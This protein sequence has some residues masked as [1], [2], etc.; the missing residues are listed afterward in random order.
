MHRRHFPDF[1]HHEGR[2][3]PAL[4]IGG[5]DPHMLVHHDKDKNRHERHLK[6]GE[7]H[8]LGAHHN[9]PAHHSHRRTPF[10]GGGI[11]GGHRLPPGVERDARAAQPHP[12]KPPHPAH[13][14]TTKPPAHPNVRPHPQAHRFVPHQ[15]PA[16]AR[17]AR[18]GNAGKKETIG[19][20]M[21]KKKGQKKA[22]MGLSVVGAAVGLGFLLY[23]GYKHRDVL[24]AGGSEAA[25][26]LGPVV[27]RVMPAVVLGIASMIVG[28]EGAIA[29]V[30]IGLLFGPEILGGLGSLLGGSEAAA[31][32]PAMR[33]AAAPAMRAAAPAAAAMMQ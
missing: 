21:Q 7:R 5:G 24:A 6:P 3:L 16:H 19:S 10:G 32:V 1:S 12:P 8:R 27:S 23:M 13:G 17:T 26:A 2:D 33:A 9:H 22:M 31:A 4:H 11:A 14:T 15:R 28:P 30:P 29:G 20:T 25:K 18:S